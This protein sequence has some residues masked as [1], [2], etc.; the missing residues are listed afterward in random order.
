MKAGDHA[1]RATEASLA[2][3]EKRM[4]A[5]G[6]KVAEIDV[7]PFRDATKAVYDKLGYGELRVEI[8]KFLAN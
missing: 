8:D 4:A 5:Q 3:Y 2:D 7:T 6:M 1:S